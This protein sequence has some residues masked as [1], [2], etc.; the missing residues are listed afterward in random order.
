MRFRLFQPEGET[1]YYTKSVIIDLRNVNTLEKSINFTLPKNAVTNSEKIEV[2]AV[3]SFLGPA[4]IHLD[5][6]I[7]LPAGCGEQNLVHFMPELIVLQYLRVTQQL[8]PTIENEAVLN[9]EKSYQQ[10]LTYK[11]EDGSF[12]PFGLRDDTGSVW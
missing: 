3:G 11:R 4:M 10:Q 6:L 2:S 12:S 9:L 1:E 5:N 8:T 7:R